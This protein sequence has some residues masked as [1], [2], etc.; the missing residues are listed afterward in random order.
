MANIVDYIDWRG[1]ITFSQ[2]PFNHIDSL[3]LCQIMYMDFE[4][5]V[6]EKVRTTTKLST[7]SKAFDDNKKY[8]E[9]LGSLINSD[10][11]SFF[12]KV[13]K[14]K[15][16]ENILLCAYRNS[17]DTEKELQF[18]SMSALLPTGE[19]CII[20]RGTDDTIIGWKEDFNMCFKSHVPAQSCALEY[21]TE[22]CSQYNRKTYVMG[23]SKGGN[24]AVY[25]SAFS[26]QKFS[27]RFIAIY[28]NDSPGF[29][30]E[31]YDDPKFVAISTKIC[32]V[33][34]EASVVGIL[35]QKAHSTTYINSSEKNAIMQH[36]IFSWQIICTDFVLAEN[37][38]ITSVVTKKT[39]DTWIAKLDTQEREQFI[40][41]LF[42][43]LNASKS[44]TL[45]GITSDWVASSVL[46]LKAMSALDKKTKDSIYNILKILL[47][48]VQVSLPPLKDLFSYGNQKIATK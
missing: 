44:Q 46:I 11:I 4:N 21:L 16:F 2:C 45:L 47:H 3:I 35:L 32:S 8:K 13:G 7:V 43:V 20:F 5:I 9:K 42:S 26:P 24:L 41:D 48:S 27:R 15:R 38:N 25:A 30:P 23:H 17:I 28:E 29:L 39:V 37:Q 34:P 10:T 36:D 18:A 14:T 40:N 22:V 31:L 12:I 6:S 33:T 19:L 1:D